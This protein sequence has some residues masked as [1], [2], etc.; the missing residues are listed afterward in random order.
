[1]RIFTTV[2][3]LVRLAV[4]CFVSGVLVGAVVLGPGPGPDFADRGSYHLAGVGDEHV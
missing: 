4:V 3:N 1:M 2:S